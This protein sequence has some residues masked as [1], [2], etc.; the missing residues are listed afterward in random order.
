MSKLYSVWVRIDRE[1]DGQRET[2]GDCTELAAF[3]SRAE[4]E[5]FCSELS[6]K[7]SAVITGEA[8]L[9]EEVFTP[10]ELTPG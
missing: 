10:N 5:G 6:L 8:E 7:Y 4:A 3:H 1:Q 2:V 9:L